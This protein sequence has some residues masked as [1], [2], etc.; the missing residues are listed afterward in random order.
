M[1]I[2][3]P[4]SRAFGIKP[5]NGAPRRRIHRLIVRPRANPRAA[6]VT[7]SVLLLIVAFLLTPEH[8][9]LRQVQAQNEGICGR[10]PEVRDA[11]LLEVQEARAAATCADVTAAE[12]A[13]IKLLEVIDVQT[14][15]NLATIID[16]S[17]PTLLSSDFAGLTSLTSLEIFRSPDLKS[18]PADA[19]A[20]T[21]ALTLLFVP[22]NGVETIHER[23]FSGLQNLESLSLAQNVVLSSLHPNVFNGLTSLRNLYLQDNSIRFLPNGVFK[24]LRSLELLE[25][26]KNRIVTIQERAFRGL[27]NVTRIELDE[28]E[29][30]RLPENVFDGLAS[31]EELL[32]SYNN[33]T[34]L[35]ADIFSGTP[36]LQ[37]LHIEEVPELT[38][39][40]P[41][42]F[43]GLDQLFELRITGTS[44]VSLPEDV[45]EPLDDS[46]GRLYL[47]NNQ[48][49][50]LPAN[51]FQGLTGLTLLLL[52]RNN[53]TELDE[54]IFDGL[55]SLNYLYL[56]NNELASLHEDVFEGLDAM[57]RLLLHGNNLVAL[58]ADVFDPF[59]DSLT[60]LYLHNNEIQTLP[61]DV[62]DGLTS[63]QRLYLD[64]NELSSLETNLFDP[65]GGSL[66]RLRLNGNEIAALHE[67]MFD[68]LAGLQWLY[69]HENDISSLHAE[70]FDGLTAL[71]RLLLHQNKIQSLDADVFDG[72]AALQTLF[73][74]HNDIA[75]LPADLFEP[76]DVGLTRLALGSN[77][78]TT[79]PA[80]IF[81]GLTG[82]AS[83]DLSCNSLTV[84]DLTLFSP[85]AS[86][87]NSLDV[88]G[89]PF[90]APPNE[91]TIRNTLS[92]LITL[93]I[94]T[95]SECLLPGDATL[96]S[97]SVSN[98]EMSPAFDPATTTYRTVVDT[99][100][101]FATI[102]FAVN[103]PT[104]SFEILSSGNHPVVDADPNDPG[105]QFGLMNCCGK[106]LITVS[107]TVTSEDGFVTRTYHLDFFRTFPKGNE[108]R[109]IRLA[110]ENVTLDR[111]FETEQEVYAAK[112]PADV[113]QVV[114][115]AATADPDATFD[116]VLDDTPYLDG[117]VDL[118]L[119]WND[120]YINVTAEDGKTKRSYRVSVLRGTPQPRASNLQ[121][122]L[123]IEPSIA[124]VTMS[125]GDEV[126]LSVEVWGRQGLLDNGLADKAPSD[127]R[128][129][130]VWSSSGGGSFQEGRVRA[131]W[132]D[133]VANDREVV[134]VA[135]DEPG[136]MTVSASVLDSGDCLSR[137]EDETEEEHEV[138]CRAEIEVTVV[139]RVTAQ[140]I[141]TAPVNPA[142]VIPAT[143]SDEDGVAY[144]I[145]TPV[146]GGNFAGDGYS[147][148][149]GAGAVANGEYIG[150]SMASAGDASNVGMT[151]HRYTLGGLRYAIGVVDA[152]G[153][154][155][156]DYGLNEAITACVPLPS[157]L[158]GNISDIVMLTV[159]DEDE[160]TT[161][162]STSVKITPDGVSVCGKLSTLPV[163]VAVGKAGSPPEVVDPAEEIED[164]GPL[165][166]TGG[167]TPVTP[168]LIWLALAGM[169]V[170]AAGLAA[171]AVRRGRRLF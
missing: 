170:T 34:T 105:I 159:P 5:E 71:T 119:G 144:A 166:D 52:D 43:A 30:T 31:L 111:E 20:G 101:E 158:R 127:G 83:L 125:P 157:E 94:G 56:Y 70:I 18:I 14:G 90:S 89:N 153:E 23:A 21:P 74:A 115:D 134:F 138:R 73:L 124:G 32:L 112:L 8:T 57:I 84:L 4:S 152:D 77:D 102:E 11:I 62:F 168:W 80:G 82:L 78:L 130:I 140:I 19:F 137:Q 146:D 87:L 76:L 162:L 92:S 61:D 9:H 150:V 147:L 49:E 12:L 39:V 99:S 38:T 24:D 44:I 120:I 93:G 96:S 54:D 51:I 68:G 65:L 160:G 97:L 139:R 37:T 91:T 148:V 163:T 116:I 88:G 117:E 7:I 42:A 75:A 86:T 28:N 161:V 59:D 16:Y 154:S 167:F 46:L 2:R 81:A 47:R 131:E 3:Y 104:A 165:P 79:L 60:Y 142:G 155:V 27:T 107:I 69:L 133:G 63:L 109:L 72:L 36:S 129:A 164:V 48:I 55:T 85:F 103:D 110:L 126:V 121:K 67:D 171:V 95:N 145:L 41:D 17:N 128:P 122:I 64:N 40:H 33:F 66:Q 53:L 143:L 6:A 45:F 136:T 106:P 135:P 149:A 29:I 13:A 100:A 26:S 98:A 22:E 169:F 132:R 10:T 151:W 113:E 50:S 114:V 123:R 141:E 108:T 25:L 118:L 35:P 58:P 15:D 1:S 156:S